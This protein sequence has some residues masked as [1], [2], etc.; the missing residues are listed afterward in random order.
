VF[1][2]FKALSSNPRSLLP[3]PLQIKKT[4]RKNM[5]ILGETSTVV[6]FGVIFPILYLFTYATFPTVNISSIEDQ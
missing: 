5:N 1:Y 6:G 4:R 3:P 2:K